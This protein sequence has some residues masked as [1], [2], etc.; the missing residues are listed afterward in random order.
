MILRLALSVLIALA[1]MPDAHAQTRPMQE[2]VTP[3]PVPAAPKGLP[4]QVTG[5]G[6]YVYSPWVKFCGRDKAD[7]A[8]PQICLTMMEVRREVGPFAAGAAL[9]EGAGE[10][11]ILRVTLPPDV[12]RSAGARISVDSETPRSGGFAACN[13]QGC[14]ADFAASPE[15]VARLKAGTLLHLRGTGPAG[16][17]KSYRLPLADFAK[18]NE[19]APSTPR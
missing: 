9:I 11:K 1:A 13:P 12:R 14:L 18:A 8:A 4:P 15:F 6:L 17:P 10:N 16:Q 3:R 2:K 7:P 5:T 19:G